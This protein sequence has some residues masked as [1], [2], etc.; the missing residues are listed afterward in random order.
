[1]IFPF[2]HS[3][4]S[5]HKLY[6]RKSSG[7]VSIDELIYL[8]YTSMSNVDVT[9]CLLIN[10]FLRFF[11]HS[12]SMVVLYD[13]PLFS[14]VQHL[15]LET[16]LLQAHVHNHY[17]YINCPSKLFQIMITCLQQ[18]LYFQD[19]G[20]QENGVKHLQILYQ[21]SL[22]SRVIQYYMKIMKLRDPSSVLDKSICRHSLL[23]LFYFLKEVVK[24]PQLK[25]AIF[26]IIGG[27]YCFAYIVYY[28]FTT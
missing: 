24:V 15:S 10:K 12:L 28:F 20:K 5:D 8:S 18:V 1:M 27:C 21:G 16:H 14:I 22:L 13:T 2:G 7:F 25:D 26:T 3:Y 19:K 11:F 4:K 17:L 9:C 6:D 23:H